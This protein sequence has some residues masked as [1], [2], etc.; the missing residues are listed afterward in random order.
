MGQQ[1]VQAVVPL[2]LCTPEVCC[3]REQAEALP[4]PVRSTSAQSFDD[5]VNSVTQT[6]VSEDLACT[7]V[8]TS[9]SASLIEDL[10]G[11]TT[12]TTFS[13][14]RLEDE[15]SNISIGAVYKH[16]IDTA[17]GEG[18]YFTGQVREDGLPQGLGVM[19]WLDGSIQSG[20][21]HAGSVHGRGRLQRSA[22]C[23]YEGEW[24][25]GVRH[26]KG[27]ER[28]ED[29]SHYRGTFISGTKHGTGCFTWPSG[30]CYTGRF[31]CGDVQ[32][33]GTLAWVDGRVYSGEWRCGKMH[34]R[35][36]FDWGDG[37][38]FEGRYEA[39]QKH[40]LGVLTWPD[41]AR[42][43]GVWRRGKQHGVCTI[44][45]AK[46][47][48]RS[49]LWNA[50][51]LVEWVDAPRRTAAAPPRGEVCDSDGTP[52][53][54]SARDSSLI[55]EIASIAPTLLATSG[56]AHS[57]DVASNPHDV[58]NFCDGA[59]VPVSARGIGNSNGSCSSRSSCKG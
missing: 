56:G 44:T 18:C 51:V 58:S 7:T 31:N 53:D 42:C 21:W 47:V 36:R 49:G 8:S 22:G 59:D 45:S 50:G 34:G 27:Y 1:H 17:I 33:I 41:T 24:A 38:I 28:Y 13:S 16:V 46:G 55:V 43:V 5:T 32:G 4:P 11:T 19:R 20:S 40:G 39:D 3:V 35:G 30:A 26:G 23:L 37:R 10:S 2:D 29:K 12:S 25:N 15:Q 6:A 57:S 14:T 52:D 9:C 54:V 48:S